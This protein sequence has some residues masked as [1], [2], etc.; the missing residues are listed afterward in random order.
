M[1]IKITHDFKVLVKHFKKK[2]E[3]EEHGGVGSAQ[4][5]GGGDEKG[6]GGGGSLHGSVQSAE[7]AL[8]ANSL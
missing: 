4:G 3:E 7:L 2:N 5:G 1:T 8:K 6:G